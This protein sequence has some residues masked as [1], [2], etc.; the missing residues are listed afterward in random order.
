MTLKPKLS[1]KLKK[2]YKVGKKVKLRF[3]VTYR[4]PDGT[5]ASKPGKV[6]LQ[7]PKKPREA[8]DLTRGLHRYT[9]P[10]VF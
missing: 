4:S 2:R 6:T 8:I 3:T 9:I 7:K 5:V 10:E 1:K